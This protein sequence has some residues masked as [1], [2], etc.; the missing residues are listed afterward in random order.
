M[1]HP[2]AW[3]VPRSLGIKAGLWNEA[4]SLYDDGE[5][6]CRV[7]LASKGVL[8]CPDAASYYRSGI[9]GSLSGSRSSDAWHAGYR[10]LKLCEEHLLACENSERTR[11]ACATSL[12]R[13]GYALYPNEPKLAARV[14]AETKSLGGSALPPPGGRVF[15]ILRRV[16]G[17]KFLR[18]IQALHKAMRICL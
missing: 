1:M 12:A 4:L 7:I 18:R 10:A 16:V 14:A 17:W 13:F 6:F 5:Y 8:F 11:H 15:Q 9:T 3:L 2:A